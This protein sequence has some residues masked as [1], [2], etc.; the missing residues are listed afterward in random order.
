MKSKCFSAGSV[1]E[2]GKAIRDTPRGLSTAKI[3]AKT[4]LS[5]YRVRRALRILKAEGA[6]KFYAQW[7][8]RNA[9]YARIY[10]WKDSQ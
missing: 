7:Y 10:L 2:V 5:L 9:G 4:G 8:G 3:V 6:I 1:F